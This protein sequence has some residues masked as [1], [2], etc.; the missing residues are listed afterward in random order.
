MYPA[1]QALH[2][3]REFSPE[4]DALQIGH[5]PE[6]FNEPLTVDILTWVPYI[7]N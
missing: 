1:I 2:Y 5:L 4:F 3:G 7:H 6:H